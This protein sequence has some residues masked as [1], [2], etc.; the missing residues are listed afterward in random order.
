MSVDEHVQR[1]HQAWP[2]WEAL[3]VTDRAQA[4][5][6]VADHLCEQFDSWVAD[7]VV[8]AHKTLPDAV[9]EVRE[10]I[11][12]ARYYAAQAMQVAQPRDLPAPTGE[13]NRWCLRGR[14]VF[15]CI[16]PWNFPLAIFGGQVMAALVMGMRSGQ[17]T[18]PVS[19]YTT[20]MPSMLSSSRSER[21]SPER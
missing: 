7:L 5:T 19:R 4:L 1:L 16:A 21:K 20:P 11:D 9:A 18:S 8:E 15:V 2:D 10:T 6:R 14:G 12:F 13:S 17:E 3:P